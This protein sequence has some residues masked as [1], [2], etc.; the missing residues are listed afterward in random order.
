MMDSN[1]PIEGPFLETENCGGFSG[2]IGQSQSSPRGRK[3]VAQAVM[4]G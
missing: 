4:P 3:S 1:L 2:G